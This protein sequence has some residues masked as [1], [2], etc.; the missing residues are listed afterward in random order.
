M[1]VNEKTLSNRQDA[2][3]TPNKTH[4]K[5]TISRP[6][7]VK[8]LKT[9]TKRKIYIAAREE[10]HYHQMTNNMVNLLFNWNNGSQNTVEYLERT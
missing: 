6:I 3:Q 9:K 8:L 5:K 4:T 1:K 10:T 7:I 2:L